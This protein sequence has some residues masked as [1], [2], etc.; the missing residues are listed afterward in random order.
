MNKIVLF[1][2]LSRPF[3]LLG[4]A[5]LYALGAGVA[6]YLGK[7]IDWDV[8]I[9]GQLWGTTLQL[10][11]HYL[12]EYY[13]ASADS[14]NPNRTL[15]SGGSGAL[16]GGGLPRQTALWA[17]VTS[18][19][20]CASLTVVIFQA[21]GFS[22]PLLVLMLLIFLGAI[23]YVLPPV[24]LAG[25]GY[26]EITTA[27]LASNLVPIFAFVL[28]TQEVH[29]LLTLSTLPLTFLHLSMM[30]AFE[31]PDYGTDLKFAKKTMMVRLG[32]EAGMRIHN[33]AI[34]GGFLLL[35]AGLFVG[36]PPRIGLP[37]LLTLPLGLFLIW[38]MN[39]IGDGMKPNWN[40]LT[41][42]AIA[43]Y[44]LTAYLIT[45]TYWIS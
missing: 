7:P 4:A 13:D 28:Q 29:R 25:S 8:Y 42:M 45:F 20:V 21:V 19:A 37:G 26:G 18:L 6:K 27:V 12:N 31:L 32:W 38:Y 16:G 39:R 44:G 34:M 23:L 11:T 43:L 40:L 41:F 22:A 30:L 5:L 10:A 3:F 14:D 36:L 9:L 2:K 24:R 33:L 1:I 15:F 35:A 17:G